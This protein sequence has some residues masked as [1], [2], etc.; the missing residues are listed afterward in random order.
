MHHVEI[1]LNFEDTQMP[2]NKFHSQV[3]LPHNHFHL[4]W[5]RVSET[6]ERGFPFLWW[7]GRKRRKALLWQIAHE[8]HQEKIYI[9]FLKRKCTAAGKNTKNHKSFLT[10]R[11]RKKFSFSL[12]TQFTIY[13]EWI[14]RSTLKFVLLWMKDG[15]FV[16]LSV[17]RWRE[18]GDK[19]WICE[20]WVGELRKL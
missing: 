2:I 12:H 18:E 19:M 4:L 1:N 11:A 14:G 17:E 15:W 9:S 20:L 6:L 5:G 3:I 10:F 8:V 16:L 13:G 7:C